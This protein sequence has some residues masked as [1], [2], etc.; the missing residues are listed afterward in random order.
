MRNKRINPT[1]SFQRLNYYYNFFFLV[2]VLIIF[3]LR[4]T[5]NSLLDRHLFGSRPFDFLR[6]ST[7]VVAAAVVVDVDDCAA[8]D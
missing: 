7:V 4:F 6:S 5:G 1:H 3:F 8:A 2:V